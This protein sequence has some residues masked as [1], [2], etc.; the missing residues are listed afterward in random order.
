MGKAVIGYLYGSRKLGKDEKFFK[1]AAKKKNAEPVLINTFQLFGK[2]D[3][4]ERIKECDIIYNSSGDDFVIEVEKTIEELG[5]KII[6]S[7]KSYYYTED[8]W[9]FF[10]KCRKHKIPTPET[11][12]LSEDIASAKADLKKFARWPVIL[13]RIIGTMGEY[14]DK[15]DNIKEAEKIINKFWKKGNEKLPVIAQEFILSPSYRVTL[16]D[17]KIVQT[18]IKK[19][20][21]WKAT[22][23]YTKKIQRF[24]LDRELEDLIKK[25]MKFIDIKVCGIDFLKKDGKW[26]ALEVNAAPAFDFFECER[27]K[28]A[29]DLVDMLKK[30]AKKN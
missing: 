25:M 17:K 11:I 24:P 8:K 1:K 2:D 6:D 5:K 29:E 28:L 18:A 4:K 10:L 22:G 3:F 23:V 26:L 9:M 13:K 15:A 7:S 16:I 19:S 12:L 21:G 20:D 14:V 27:G 30:L